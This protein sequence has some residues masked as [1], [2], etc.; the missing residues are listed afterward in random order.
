MTD[1]LGTAV[2]AITVILVL[3]A[4]G[5]IWWVVRPDV[6]LRSHHHSDDAPRVLPLFG[7]DQLTA[8][9]DDAEDGDD[10]PARHAPALRATPARPAAAVL[11]RPAAPIDGHE[12]ILGDRRFAPHPRMVDT[13]APPVARPMPTPAN[14]AAHHHHAA[15]SLADVAPVASNG[16]GRARGLESRAPELR[17]SAPPARPDGQA[18]RFSV[19]SDGTLQFLPGRLEVEAGAEL[20]REIRFVRTAGPDGSDVTFGRSEGALYR[21]VQLHDQTVSRLHA[22]MRMRDGQWHLTN[23]STTNPLALNG[24]V[25]GDEEEQPLTDGDR[26]EMGEVIFRFRSR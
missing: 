21:H 13:M 2:L 8:A 1:G 20:G 25:L 10:A 17:T 12:Q 15:A 26:I 11:D 23:L 18:M 9:E 22:R 14:G 24:R 16:N 4:I 7:V 5:L 3:I 19:P 6:T